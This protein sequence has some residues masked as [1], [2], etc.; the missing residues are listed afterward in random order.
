MW[1]RIVS[2]FGAVSAQ[3]NAH[4]ADSVGRIRFLSAVCRKKPQC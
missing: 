4:T 3:Q 1:N 2:A